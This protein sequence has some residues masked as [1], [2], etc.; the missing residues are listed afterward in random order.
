MTIIVNVD[1]ELNCDIRIEEQ[2][3]NLSNAII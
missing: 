3:Y 1:I 2:T